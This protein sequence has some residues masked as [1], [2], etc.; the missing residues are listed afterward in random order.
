MS[1]VPDYAFLREIRTV[2]IVKDPSILTRQAQPGQALRSNEGRV[3]NAFPGGYLVTTPDMDVLFAPPVGL[4]RVRLRRDYHFG[5]DDPLFYPQPF[6]RTIAHLAL[7]PIPNSHP[8]HSL[9]HAWFTPT[10]RDFEPRAEMDI[11]PRLSKLRSSIRDS[12]EVMAAE[13]LERAKDHA[14]DHYVSNQ[15]LQLRFLLGRLDKQWAARSETFLRFALAQRQFLGLTA[16]LDWIAN[17]CD[18]YMKPTEHESDL[19]CPAVIGAF[20]DS[21]E[22]VEALFWL[23]IPVWYLRPISKDLDVRVDRVAEFIRGSLESKKLVLPS[24]FEVDLSKGQSSHRVIYEGLANKPERYLAMSNYLTSIQQYPSIFGSD[25]PRSSTSLARVLVQ[26]PGAGSSRKGPYSSKQ[27]RHRPLARRV[28]KAPPDTSPLMPPPPPAW[29]NALLALSGL[30]QSLPAPDGFNGGYVLPPAHLLCSPQNDVTK[31]CFISNWLKL[32][33]LLIY[34]LT[35]SPRR[36]SNKQWRCFLEVGG[37]SSRNVNKSTRSG[38][39]FGEMQRL[40]EDLVKQSLLEV[41]LENLHTSR[42]RWNTQDLTDGEIPD[43]AVVKEVAWELNELNF[44]QE[45]LILDSHLDDSKMSSFDRQRLLDSCWAG[46]AEYAIVKHP[47]RGLGGPTIADRKP[48]LRVLHQVMS[49]WRIEKCLELLD[50]FPTDTNA[51][52]FAHCVEQVEQAVASS[53]SNVFWDIFGR[54]PTV[55]RQLP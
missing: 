25:E 33:H 23:G 32:R 4:C 16:R 30:N 8:A 17:F 48:Y 12:F 40:L 14:D 1:S 20:S 24:G 2:D 19:G 5:E 3:G 28:P 49:T 11:C 47:S 10:E 18:R 35:V 41:H 13:A 27:D 44:R 7:I 52:N 46:T 21:P 29:Q 37:S 54:P 31:G 15:S 9:Y 22:V 39:Q 55:P 38:K 26:L 34:R 45:L 43:V 42:P 50:P 53:Y 51:H 36:L 6:N